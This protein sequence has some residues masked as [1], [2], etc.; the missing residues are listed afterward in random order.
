MLELVW[1]PCVDLP[2]GE[3]DGSDQLVYK[4]TKTLNTPLKKRE[5]SFDLPLSHTRSPFK[6][7]TK[8]TPKLYMCQSS[9]VCW[10]GPT[11]TVLINSGQ[12]KRDSGRGKGYIDSDLRKDSV[13]S[14]SP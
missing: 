6:T 5:R 10:N 2:G 7:A 13:I 4:R 9:G 1:I 3:A 8:K 11:E 14:P 12:I